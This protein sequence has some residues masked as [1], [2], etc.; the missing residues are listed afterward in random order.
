MTDVVVLPPPG[1][2]LPP[3]QPPWRRLPLFVA[4][5]GVSMLLGAAVTAGVLVLSGWRY[6]P[7]RDY[8]VAV[9]LRAEATAEQKEAVRAALADMPA[10]GD[11]RLETSAEAYERFKKLWTDDQQGMPDISPDA[12]PESFH[13]TIPGDTVDCG[14]LKR[15]GKQPGVQDVVTTGAGTKTEP[16]V[17]IACY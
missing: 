17:T 2:P 9:F 4:I 5:S 10:E 1:P 15:L 14:Q 16:P 13:L 8:E 3:P 6:E 12:L 7:E 11:V